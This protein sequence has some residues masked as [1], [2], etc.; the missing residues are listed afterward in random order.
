MS[1]IELEKITSVMAAIVYFIL[2]RL[3]IK[4][5]G[6]NSILAKAIGKDLKGKMPHPRYIAA[7][8][9]TDVRAMRG[10][11]NVAYPRQEN[12]GHYS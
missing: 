11:F 8:I 10:L 5:H 7:I 12:R 1:Q 9:F 2:Q 6:K 4:T 3:I